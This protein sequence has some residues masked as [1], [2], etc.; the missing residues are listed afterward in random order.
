VPTVP[1]FFES[2][3]AR[4]GDTPAVIFGGSVLTYADLDVR[5]NR[6]ARLLVSRGVGPDQI[7]AVTMPKSD[8][9]MVVLLAV[10]KAGGAYLPL[11]PG[12]PTDRLTHMVR[13]ARPVLLVRTA[14]VSSIAGIEVAELI[15]DHRDVE[16]DVENRPGHDLTD[17]CR[18]APLAPQHLMYVIY[19]SG[20][21]GVPKGVAVTHSGVADIV[22]AQAASIAPRPGDRV[23]QW[24][25]ISFDAAFWDWSAALLSGAT[26]VMAAAEDLLPGPP[27]HETLRRHGI[28]H[29]VLPPMALSATD[30][31]GVL[32]GGT[33]M[34]TG[35]ACTAALVNK[36]SPGRRMFNGY[37]PTETTVGATIAGPVSNGEQI[38]IGTP[39]RGNGVRVLDERLREVPPETA[40]E[41]YL[42]GNGLARG[43]LG[44][45]GLTA[46]R[47]VPDP[48]GPP[49]GRLYRSGDH[50]YRRPDGQLVFTGRTD[51]QVKIRGF[52]VELGEVET[53]LATHA[54]VDVAAAVVIGDL[55]SAT[56]VGCVCLVGGRS[57][58]TAE[59]RAHVAQTLPEHM[60]PSS[61]LV[62]ERLP[63]N[64]NG[65]IDRAALCEW[66][67]SA[68][69]RSGG[70]RT[71]PEE[72]L[73]PLDRTLCS[74][75]EEILAVPKV[76]PT[77]NFFEL[78]GHSVLATRL[79]TRLRAELDVSVPMRAVLEAATLSDLATFLQGHLAQAQRTAGAGRPAT[80]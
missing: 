41:L 3:A 79:A 9:L 34:S 18:N 7:V 58:D 27:L 45:P 74:L 23:L 77:D 43:Y 20:S 38:T 25:S 72:S 53:R 51:G 2:V 65:K 16:R 46:A 80:G 37:G 8:E 22:T 32:V 13:D 10:L 24:A 70:G 73:S 29:A 59:L 42:S 50:G 68:P 55:D 6:L 52:R 14:E 33:V 62:L 64:A 21:T 47:F 1:E 76:V 36:W 35:D 78:G 30:Q 56:L 57:A 60:V 44:R 69:A 12:Y 75:V 67:R 49:G 17:N 31:R 40:G 28:T 11:D 54:A 61:V 26:L 19:T 63:V 4:M 66:V 5:A 71:P 39:W 48:F 15:V